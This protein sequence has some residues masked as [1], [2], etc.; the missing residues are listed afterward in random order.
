MFKC[1]S[2]NETFD[3][4]DFYTERHGLDTP[5]FEQIPICPHCGSEFFHEQKP[6][7]KDSMPRTKVI[8][9]VLEAA[10][11]LN[12]FDEGMCGLL[13][14]SAVLDESPIGDARSKLYDLICEAADGD[15]ACFQDMDRFFFITTDQ[16]RDELYT[17]LTE[18]IA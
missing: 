8:E 9:L 4:A 10:R 12:L 5:P 18:G 6:P 11:Q 17:Q 13:K 7:I 3:V 2:C 14:N 1:N 16:Q 15:D